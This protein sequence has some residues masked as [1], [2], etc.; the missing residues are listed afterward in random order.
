M[1]QAPL[2]A[3][4]PAPPLQPSWGLRWSSRLIALVWWLCLATAV[5]F[6]LSWVALHAIIVP[7]IDELRPRLEKQLGQ[8]LGA[9]V[10][11]GSI[12][13]ESQTLAPSFELRDVRLQDSTGRDALIL[14]KVTAALSP[15]SMLHLGLEQLVIEQPELD[16]RRN[17]QGQLSIAGF[18][19]PENKDDSQQDSAAAD[20]LLSQRE[21]VIRSGTVLWTD[22]LRGATPLP[23]RDVD[24]VLRSN[25]QEHQLRLDAT[26]PSDWGDRFSAMAQFTSPLWSSHAGQWREWEG[27]AFADFTRIDVTQVHRYADTGVDIAQGLGAVRSWLSFSKGQ[28]TE[29]TA[30]L[31]LS[32]MD[33]RLGKNVAPLAVQAVNSR[34]ALQAVE[35]GMRFS[36][37]GLTFRTADGVQWPGGNIAFLQTGH[38]ADHAGRGELQADKL[39]LAVMSQIVGR[40]PLDTATHALVRSLDPKGQV[41]SVQA[42]WQGHISAPTAYQAQGRASALAL[43][44]QAP[45]RPGFSGAAVDFKLNQSGGQAKLSIKQGAID[46][47]SA[48]D[49][50]VIPL[51]ALDTQAQWTIDGEK[52]SLQLDKLRFANADAQGELQAHWETA[53]PAKSSAKSRF[54][55]VLDLQGSL[56]RGEGTQVFRYLPKT[57]DKFAR[58]YVRNAV[59]K[60]R[61]TS[62]QF[63]VKG[64]LFDL[65]FPNPQRGEFRI[66]TQIEDAQFAFVPESVRDKDSLPWPALTQLKG[67]LVF[68]RNAMHLN[69][70]TGRMGQGN[71]LQI[72]RGD[73]HIPDLGAPTTTVLVNTDNRGSLA[74]MLALINSTP[75]S[76]ITNQALSKTK[77]TGIVDLKLHLNLPLDKIANSK[78][79][80][81]LSLPGNDVQVTPESPMLGNAKGLVTFNETGFALSSVQA[82]MLGGDILIDGGTRVGAGDNESSLLFRAQGHISA[83][84]LRQAKELGFVSRIADNASGSAAYTATLGFRRSFPELVISSDLQGMALSLPPPLNKAPESTL[85]L[86]Y[87]NSLTNDAATSG[88]P[89]QD[90][91]LLD[92]G[93]L[94]SIMYVRD[95]SGAQPRVVRGS[96]GVGL[97]PG[98]SA[99]ATQDGVVANINFAQVNLDAWEKVLRNAAGAPAAPVN[100]AGESNSTVFTSTARAETSTNAFSYIPSVMAVRARELTLQGRVLH[101][102]VVGGSRD[103]LTWRANLDARELNGYV[104]FRQA[105]ANHAG[106]VYARLARLNIAQSEAASIEQVL[107]EP[108][109]AIPALDIVVEDLD[110]L[111]K[112]LGRAEI[113]ATNRA[114]AS[115]T[116]DGG[117]REWRL[118][119]LNVSMPEAQFSA[120]G[121]W[122]AVG[123]TLAGPRSS[124]GERRRA[125]LN[126]KLDIEDSGELL[127]R[128]G[129]DKLIARGKG[130][131]EG[132][133]AWIGSP[134]SL[135]YPSLAGNFNVD[136]E[137]GRFLKADPGLAKLLGVLSLQTLPRRLTLDFRDVF[138]D[139]F[140]FDFIRGDVK[141]EQGVANTNNLQMKG[142]NAAVLMEG[143][144]NIAKETQDMRVVVVPEINAG[145]ASL[146]AAVINPAIGL[147]TF[148]AQLIL[149]KPVIEAATQEFHIDGA[150]A[151]PKI[152]KVDR[153]LN[154][155][156][157]STTDSPT[158]LAN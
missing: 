143:T 101:N 55:G 148:L 157:P 155:S 112:K 133:V 99:P 152:T 149:R 21:L 106:S 102:I 142:V 111:G 154:R 60:G 53:D 114:L 9:T 47:P 135:D 129:M 131:M 62:A 109:T 49:D 88:K 110:L 56:S 103:G 104:E 92:L 11:I 121:N 113:E 124:A 27:Q 1:P 16:I 69:N 51:D 43:A 127:K 116:P 23:L 3:H 93:A 123:N 6:A 50:P 44:S 38:S 24:V 151:D 130:L 94:A 141:I 153:K 77:A 75:L 120:T 29:G 78:V 118:N 132:Q 72:V 2:T 136:I 41:D 128:F 96:I 66:A 139:G 147:G 144:A 90:Q 25:G 105:S 68:D 107:E 58:D 85:A 138:S 119:K 15:R 17:A 14:A 35:D 89:L 52:I 150:W 37:E 33:V 48:F 30:D 125:V 80:G 54:P 95:I 134:F 32:Q 73:A 87:E 71:S 140:S 20:W 36:T 108:P 145:T 28:F 42:Q 34:I 97:A 76:E 91:V 74:D 84:N 63:K 70:A 98:E 86:R 82:N 22:E 5:V 26:P 65:P 59:E 83:D 46:L 18:A 126:F 61:I 12:R 67:E 57:I 81:T 31:A 158:E 10:R 64:D 39:D 156:N 7:R 100:A 40:L 146:V 122:T 79:A 137:S 8:T 45:S 13:A 117:A 19:L 115:T 4:P